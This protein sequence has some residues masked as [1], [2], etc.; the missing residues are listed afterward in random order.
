M[1]LFPP[2]APT[3]WSPAVIPQHIQE[4]R[5]LTWSCQSAMPQSPHTC[6]LHQKRHTNHKQHPSHISQTSFRHTA[7]RQTEVVVTPCTSPHN[8]IVHTPRTAAAHTQSNKSSSDR[9]PPR[10]AVGS[11]QKRR[12][13]KPQKSATTGCK[14]TERSHT[15]EFS[16]DAPSLPPSPQKLQRLKTNAPS[17]KLFVQSQKKPQCLLLPSQS[18]DDAWMRMVTH[19]YFQT[20]PHTRDASCA[21]RHAALIITRDAHA[22]SARNKSSRNEG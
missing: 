7:T 5:K 10:A 17:N 20:T 1:H 6:R 9:W 19:R 4:C 12:A 3:R 13:A 8:H 2:A 21:L 14:S 16:P 15:N 18:V 11:K 22:P